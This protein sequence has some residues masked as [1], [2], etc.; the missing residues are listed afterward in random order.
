[1]DCL[2]AEGER[3]RAELE[4]SVQS[5]KDQKRENEAKQEKEMNLSVKGWRKKG[6]KPS[7]NAK[8]SE[9]DCVSKR[10]SERW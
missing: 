8:R 1:M 7:K 5:V 10:Q 4:E 6:Y 3:L 2:T 9:C